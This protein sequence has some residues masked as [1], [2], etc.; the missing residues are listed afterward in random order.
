MTGKL[1]G[2]LQG[3]LRDGMPL[4]LSENWQTARRARSGDIPVADLKTPEAHIFLTAVFALSAFFKSVRLRPL[5]G[6]R[7]ECRRSLR[8]ALLPAIVPP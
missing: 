5:Q 1:E 7:Q 4:L 6:R 8:A 3:G 2:E